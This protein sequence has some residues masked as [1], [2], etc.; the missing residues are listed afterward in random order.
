MNQFYSEIG[1]TLKQKYTDTQAWLISANMEAL[2]HIGLHPTRKIK[3]FNGKLETRL[4]LY[5]IYK[6]TKK[7][8]KLKQEES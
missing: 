1:D 8:H 7:L 3:L 4:S 6:G 5:S 2:K